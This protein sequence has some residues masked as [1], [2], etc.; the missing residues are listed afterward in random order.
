LK[1]TPKNNHIEMPER[2]EVAACRNFTDR[3]IDRFNQN[4]TYRILSRIK[5]ITRKNSSMVGGIPMLI[6][7]RP[8]TRNPSAKNITLITVR[9]AMNFAFIK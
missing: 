4:A 5:K 7:P 2:A 8:M 3:K 6:R 9:D 1:K